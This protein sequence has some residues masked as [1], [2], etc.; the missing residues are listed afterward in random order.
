MRKSAVKFK[1]IQSGFW[2]GLA[3][4]VVLLIGAGTLSSPV[5]AEG[6][7]L[8]LS[9]DTA[10]LS[11]LLNPFNPQRFDPRKRRQIGV[12]PQ[13]SE[14]ALGA[15]VN[16]VGDS[17]LHATIL[18]KGVHIPNGRLY[19]FGAGLR[20]IG[21]DLDIDE[22]VSALALGF[23]TLVMLG[24]AATTPLDFIVEG[25]YAP[26][27]SSFGDAENYVELSA[28]LQVEIIGQARAYV[29]YRRL[30][31]DTN[32]FGDQ[33]LDNGVHLGLNITF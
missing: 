6:L 2:A 24:F 27:I 17:L 23:H 28:R 11:V 8:A 30:T 15:F 9:D 22:N 31:F 18:T 3:L 10:N 1:K 4:S 7:D 5:R 20:V 12:V 13:G 25:W 26:G 21:G 16:E 29:G 19:K 14:L 32:D 33:E